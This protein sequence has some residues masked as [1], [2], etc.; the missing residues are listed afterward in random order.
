MSSFLI[1]LR[2]SLQKRQLCWFSVADNVIN[3]WKIGGKLE[4][5]E[6]SSRPTQKNCTNAEVQRLHMS[7]RRHRTT[8]VMQVV[9]SALQGI[10]K[11]CLGPFWD[12]KC[13]CRIAGM[14]S[15]FLKSN[16]RTS[17]IRND[18]ATAK[19]PEMER[20]FLLHLPSNT[21]KLAVEELAGPHLPN[22]A[23]EVGTTLEFD[24]VVGERYL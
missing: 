18:L 19:G 5:S 22:E 16:L 21:S 6:V 14:L 7:V 4:A 20:A 15:V 9:A 8:G 24:F 13:V 3:Q 17:A 23:Q 1:S 10:E 11:C 12:G 2:K